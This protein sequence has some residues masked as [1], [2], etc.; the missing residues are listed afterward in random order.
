MS[1]LRLQVMR[2]GDT[3]YVST[4]RFATVDGSAVGG[5]DYQPVNESL[6][7]Q[8][9]QTTAEIEIPILANPQRN[10]DS[11]FTVQLSLSISVPNTS[12]PTSNPTVL[13]P[14]S[15]VTVVIQDLDLKGPYFPALPVVTNTVGGVLLNSS[16]LYYDLPLVCI[17]V[18]E[19][20]CL[21]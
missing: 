12:D 17:T 6:V 16:E 11:F 9:E 21:T 13:G 7:F 4:V 19:V 2:T 5:M 3:N 14:V 8:K 15:S 1:S 10:S 20:L 18:S